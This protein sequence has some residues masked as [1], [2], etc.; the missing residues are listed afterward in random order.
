G[1]KPGRPFPEAAHEPPAPVVPD[2]YS[3]IPACRGE[4]VSF[5]REGDRAD[6]SG[7]AGQHAV[8]AAGVCQ[9]DPYLPVM[10]ARGEVFPVRGECHGADEVPVAPVGADQL[11]GGGVPELD[12]P[13]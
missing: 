11:T 10:A 1:T 9:P 7:L 13:V 6:L 4:Q 8:E 5:R 3:A 2:P 12:Q